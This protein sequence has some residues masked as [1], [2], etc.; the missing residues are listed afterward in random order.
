MTGSQVQAAFPREGY[1]KSSIMYSYHKWAFTLRSQ[2]W[3]A[4]YVKITIGIIKIFIVAIDCNQRCRR[5]LSVLSNMGEGQH[6]C[7]PILLLLV[8]ASH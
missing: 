6:Q 1:Q 3:G 7:L 4:S 5:V 2:L 8:R